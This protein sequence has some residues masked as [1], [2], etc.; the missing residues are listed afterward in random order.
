M[1]RILKRTAFVFLGIV[2]MSGLGGQVAHADI[3]YTFIKLACAS[4]TDN[5][6]ISTF[7]KWNEDG[8]ALTNSNEPNVY[9]LDRIAE[10]QRNIVCE[11][12]NGQTVSFTALQD[13]GHP[14]NNHLV[15]RINNE[16]VRP[17]KWFSLAHES[18]IDIRL[19]GNKKFRIDACDQSTRRAKCET[20]TVHTGNAATSKP[21]QQ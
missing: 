21:I 20:I 11:F 7:F 16:E 15:L 17:M 10:E 18:V 13:A 9:Y 8:E 6:T 2:L 14:R 3:N 4:K 19:V 5:A 12:K 1:G